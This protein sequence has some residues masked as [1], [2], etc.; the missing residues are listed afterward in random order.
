MNQC[1][2]R[3]RLAVPSLRAIAEVATAKLT[4]LADDEEMSMLLDLEWQMS[5]KWGRMGD[6]DFAASRCLLNTVEK[7]RGR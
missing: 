1:G 5:S 2:G 3:S 7:F 6:F 4:D